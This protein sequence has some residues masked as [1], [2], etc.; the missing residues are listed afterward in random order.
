MS[1]QLSVHGIVAQSFGAVVGC[2]EAIDLAATEQLVLL[3]QFG[4]D[5]A[6]CPCLLYKFSVQTFGYY[7]LSMPVR[8]F[9]QH[10]QGGA[11]PWNYTLTST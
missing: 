9:P 3:L 2:Q 1:F 7:K 5:D 4:W 8:T 10:L 6:L 11:Y